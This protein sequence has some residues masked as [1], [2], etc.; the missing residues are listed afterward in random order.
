MIKVYENAERFLWEAEKALLEREAVSQLLLGNAY[1]NR[2]RDCSL[3]CFF[4]TVWDHGKMVLAF[5]NCLPWNLV[6]HAVEEAG[7]KG[8]DGEDG[9]QPS[10]AD[11]KIA[12]A[13]G[14]LAA[15][16][17]ERA[18]PLNGINANGF[19]CSHFLSNYGAGR[20]FARK[21]L[22]MDIMECKAL[23][24]PA[25]L[26]GI[27]RAAEERDLD[28]ILK[29]CL[30]FER[31][32]LGR[33][34]DRDELRENIIKHQIGEKQ[35][36]LF[37]LPDDTPVCM[38]KQSTRRLKNGMVITQVYTQPKYRGMGYAQTLIFKMCEEIFQ[39]GYSFATLFVDK[40]NPISN[41][42]YEKV[43][44]TVLED[45]YDYKFTQEA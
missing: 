41:R 12:A 17:E 40:T 36:R 6:I 9:S 7:Q 44:F 15:F 31:E 26:S 37:C 21:Y 22:S 43:G 42:V 2:D 1:A 45:N 19:I 14:E 28:W 23:T 5:C 35:G 30:A 29:G 10:T 32:A 13:S 39:S 4:G 11:E 24:K 18:I 33:E 27:Y 20:G 25:L 34:G 38:A 8:N 16:M 3:D